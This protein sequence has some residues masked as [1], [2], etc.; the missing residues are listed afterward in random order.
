[1]KTITSSL[2]K[3]FSI[4]ATAILI[5]G[6]LNTTYLRASDDLSNPI[7]P[8]A[9][10]PNSGVTMGH[11]AAGAS[12]ARRPGNLPKYGSRAHSYTGV[13]SETP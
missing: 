12:T 1:M 3:Q 2:T 5:A 8:N 9:P 13:T 10:S 7:N 4:L 11:R 6:S